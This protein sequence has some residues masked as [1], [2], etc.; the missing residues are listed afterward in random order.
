MGSH[1]D[2]ALRHC[3]RV[4]PGGISPRFFYVF[5][6]QEL[7]SCRWVWAAL[8]GMPA[9]RPNCF[10][11]VRDEGKHSLGEPEKF[12]APIG[13]KVPD[14]F[15]IHAEVLMHEQVSESDD[16]RPLN[17][18]L[19]IPSLF[20]E[21]PDGFADILKVTD[22]GVEQKIVLSKLFERLSLD[23]TLYPLA[24]F[25]DVEQVEAVSTQP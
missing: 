2:G 25:H 11:L 7:R 3:P 17:F 18:R 10:L 5:L 23:K 19:K 22:R 16:P 24:C 1:P 21:T 6:P 9:I 12:R 14:D 15:D 8:A 4:G 20:G 13:G